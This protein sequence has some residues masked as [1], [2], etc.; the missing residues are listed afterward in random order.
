MQQTV[1]LDPD[2]DYQQSLGLKSM[3]ANQKSVFKLLINQSDTLEFPDVKEKSSYI[4]LIFLQ[5][6][7]R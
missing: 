2:R 5:G 3:E 1:T 6:L 4:A 7:L